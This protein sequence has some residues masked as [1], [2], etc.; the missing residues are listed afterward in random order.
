[1]IGG[2]KKTKKKEK[3]KTLKA[4]VPGT[5]PARDESNSYFREENMKRKLLSMLLALVMVLGTFGISAFATTTGYVSVATGE[6]IAI[7]WSQSGTNYTGTV[8]DAYTLSS[9]TYTMPST[10][11]LW[12]RGTPTFTYDSDEISVTYLYDSD[13]GQDKA[14][15]VNV[16]NIAEGTSSSLTVVID[17]G[18][19]TVDLPAATA[20][21]AGGT[22]PSYVN[23][24][25]PVGLI[26]YLPSRQLK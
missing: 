13:D 9:T 17:S 11:T 16:S 18:T 2:A 23:G 3:S 6:M 24:Y 1:M 20:G 7:D 22:C 15:Q 19:Y 10:F 5:I 4:N 14:Y 21:A 12:T 26:C 25:L 8:V